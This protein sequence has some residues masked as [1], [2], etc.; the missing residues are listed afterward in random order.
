MKTFSILL[1]ISLSLPGMT[2]ANVCDTSALPLCPDT[3][4]RILDDTYPPRAFVISAGSGTDSNTPRGLLPSRTIS[5][6]FRAY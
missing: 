2:S 6:V 3:G 1:A 5:E 4:V